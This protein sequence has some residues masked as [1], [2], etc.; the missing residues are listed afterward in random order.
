MIGGYR[1]EITGKR[2]ELTVSLDAGASRLSGTQMT[3]SR[4]I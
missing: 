3:L 4:V 1:A 2:S